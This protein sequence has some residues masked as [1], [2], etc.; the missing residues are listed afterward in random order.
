MPNKRAKTRKRLRRQKNKWL[1]EHGR[2]KR[3]YRRKLKKKKENND[4]STY[5]Y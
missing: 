5:L 1:E 2:T 4:K 3:Q